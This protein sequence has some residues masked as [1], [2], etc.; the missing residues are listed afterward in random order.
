M[1]T[2]RGTQGSIIWNNFKACLYFHRTPSKMSESEEQ[3]INNTEENSETQKTGEKSAE[4]LAAEEQQSTTKA[5][6]EQQR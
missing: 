2:D 4:N 5:P 1:A 3:A 6:G